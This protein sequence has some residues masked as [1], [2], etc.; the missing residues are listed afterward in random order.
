MIRAIIFDL[1]K[2]IVPFDFQRGY[3]GLEPLCGIPAAQIPARLA[4]TGLVHRFES[5]EVEPRDFFRQ[6]AGH[7]NLNA[8]YD[9][10]CRIWSSIFLPETLIPE[11]TIAKLARNYPLIL[12]SNTNAIHFEMIRENYPILRHFRDM[13]LSYRVGATKPAPIIY[14]KAIEAAGCRAEECFYTDD[15]EEYVFAAREQGMD[16]VQFHSAAQIGDELR[17]RGV[18]LDGAPPESGDLKDEGAKS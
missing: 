5:G 14:R 10:F 2:V 7:L 18:E 6:L 11:S 9:D 3:A 8:S 4:P 16:A 17:R 15:I 12:L 13:V 1:G